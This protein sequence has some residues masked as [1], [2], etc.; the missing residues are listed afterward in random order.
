MLR[1]LRRFLRREPKG[2][3]ECQDVR[4]LASDYL[5]EEL[6]PTLVQRFASHL[7]RCCPCRAFVQGLRSTVELLRTM[8]AKEPPPSFRSKLQDRLRSDAGKTKE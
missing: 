3:L 7:E 1:R 2:E 6:S 5:E 4:E 8:P